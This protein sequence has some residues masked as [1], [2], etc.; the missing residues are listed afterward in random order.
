MQLS[1]P[2]GPS[3]RRLAILFFL[4]FFHTTT[5]TLPTLHTSNLKIFHASSES[6]V[7]HKREVAHELLD[8][9]PNPTEVR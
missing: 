3:G 1:T 5:P 2:P 7:R 4:Y 6:V 9:N 8:S